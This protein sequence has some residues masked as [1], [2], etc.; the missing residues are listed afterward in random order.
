MAVDSES[1]LNQ[2]SAPRHDQRFVPR[3]LRDLFLPRRAPREVRQAVERWLDAEPIA[4]I[5]PEAC[6]LPLG[7]DL[8]PTTL[9]TEP[10]HLAILGPPASGRS[11]ALAQFA[12]NW[13]ETAP[14]VPLIHLLLSNLDST[15]LTPR[16]IVAR[17]LA[18]RNL[19]PNPLEHNLPCFL[20]IDDWEELPLARR[21]IWQRFLTSL[22]E[23]WP[24]ARVVIA[25]PPGELWPSFRHHAIAPLNSE[26]LPDWIKRLFPHLD[27]QAVLALF[28]RDPL[29]LLRE[30]PAELILLA[31]TQPLSGW[32]VSRATLYERAAAFVAP[33][34]VKDAAQ[35]GW[36]IGRA[37]YQLYQQAIALAAQSAPQ[38]EQ[39][40][41][42]SP[43]WRALCVP[44]AFGTSPD[45]QPIITGLR[46]AALSAH[47]RLLLL[48]RALRERPRLDPAMSR[49][50]LDEICQHGGE[51]L[52]ILA[53]ALPA[54]LMNI[55]QSQP[56][57]ALEL[58]QQ[59]LERLTPAASISLLVTLLDAG[60]AP[61]G[62]RWQA[63]DL[64]IQRNSLPPPLPAEADLIAQAGRCLIAAQSPT[65]I[66]Q[67]A[68]PK[69]YLGLRLLLSGAAGSERQQMIARQLLHHQHLP[70]AVRMLAP[71]ALSAGELEQA[72][73][74]PMPEVRQAARAVWIRA[75]QIDHLARFALNPRQPWTARAECI[76]SLA[77]TAAGHTVLAGFALGDRIPLELRLQAI[78]L[79]DR[80][81]NG[82]DLLSRL[83]T[84]PEELAVARAMAALV[85]ARYPQ[86]VSLLSSLLGAQQPP[87]TRRAAA[88]A[89]GQLA[90]QN[91]LNGLAARAILLAASAQPDLDVTVSQTIVKALGRCGGRQALPSLGRLLAPTYGVDLLQAW[92][93]AL[94]ALI[95][96][97]DQWLLRARRPHIQAILAD[98]LA[99]ARAP[100]HTP[101]ELDRPSA[102]IALQIMQL[103]SAVIQ[104][105]GA[106]GATHP[107]LKPAISAL[108]SVA[109]SDT[110]VP[111]PLAEMAEVIAT[112]PFCDLSALA[113]AASHD[114]LLRA[115]VLQ[116]LAH[117]PDG[118]QR[119]A[120]LIDTGDP[121][122]V[123]AALKHM[124]ATTDQSVI[125]ALIAVARNAA[126]DEATRIE[127]L[128]A[129]GRSAI[130]SVT[131][132]LLAIVSRDDESPAV[133]AAA[134]DA[135]TTAPADA[136]LALVASQPEPIRS[137][138][139]RALAR[140]AA[141]LPL[142]LLH[143]LAFDPD[144]NC[145]LA[146]VSA[147]AS[148]PAAAT[149]II[150][151]IVRHHPD[152]AVRLAAAAAL[153]DHA[154]S[155]AIVVFCEALA[156]PHPALQLQG[157]SLL[158]TTEP[159]H[160]ALRQPLLDAGAPDVLRFAA[161][162]HLS[163]I[164]PADPL[165]RQLACNPETSEAL[166]CHAITLLGQCADD[167]TI[168]CLARLADA[169][170]QPL[171]VRHVAVIA[172]DRLYAESL[173]VEALAALV[174]LARSAN[175]EA[176][177]WA[178]TVLLNRL[179]PAS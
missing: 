11:L 58:L 116:T 13:L 6:S 134:L 154:A 167:E 15:S 106:I 92:I 46:E 1:E 101:I 31:M 83:A 44:L 141:P 42:A 144:R 35:D 81:S 138:A 14:D 78:A 159:H 107:A 49:P 121:P 75:G 90:G 173:N 70:A 61:P 17:A 59:V 34:L 87:L 63:I 124:P 7:I 20:L 104:A 47:E 169:D 156:S 12:R 48:A 157:F 69:L 130:S 43:L 151:R 28:E 79:L 5:Y 22:R 93:T 54:I 126:A 145:A 158:A 102:L 77:G 52:A 41:S 118:A 62:L 139:L 175:P 136:L 26:R 24:A 51:A 72:A 32:P 37:A 166:R 109:M 108:I 33:I 161:L 100:D 131:P 96:P 153:R 74:D 4:R 65:T 164:A 103:G 56:T 23:R 127:A 80:L 76:V 165:I 97:A 82:F 27:Q 152:L 160:P 150:T 168:A 21:A 147:L 85:L 128:Q 57:A 142:P 98:L 91:N 179:G 71:V 129:L 88:Q 84:T 64:L 110:S 113:R 163:A 155:E 171:T 146:A 25:L 94:P 18:R 172:L 55:G 148:Q 40:R 68:D 39:L 29:A 50:L 111:R 10:H 137:A 53:P 149:T 170:D 16:A 2:R 86:S 178:G 125:A 73:V 114:P 30:R 140:S 135:M 115:A 122:L 132:E 19:A 105:L 112:D 95:G 38:P 66:S 60:D 174:A 143:R 67:V 89:L 133:R 117:L 177:L 9:L 45:P 8:D 123:I 36:R 99:S 162:N 119:L 120:Q 3:T 176:A